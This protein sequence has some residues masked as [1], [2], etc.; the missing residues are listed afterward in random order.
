LSGLSLDDQLWHQSLATYCRHQEVERATGARVSPDWAGVQRTDDDQVLLKLLERGVTDQ[1]AF[2]RPFDAL[3]HSM[4]FAAVI[5]D[6]LWSLLERERLRVRNH[7][8][9]VCSMSDD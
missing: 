3:T 4:C 2:D 7:L 5:G 8:T 1:S 9:F 6:H